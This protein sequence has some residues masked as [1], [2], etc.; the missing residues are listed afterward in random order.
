MV[1]WVDLAAADGP[2][3]V[4][5]LAR[6]PKLKGIRPMIQDIPDPD[7]MLRADLAP[8][9]RA[10]ADLDLAFDALVTPRHLDALA[11][12]L[13]RYGD[14]RV[15]IDHA[16]KPRIRD[17]QFEPW[18]DQMRRIARSSS[19][20]CKLSGLLTEAGPNCSIE[21]LR[22]Y[23]DHLLEVFGPERLVFGSDWPVLTL[24]CDYQG[25]M[26]TSRRLLD[27]L[28]PSERGRIYGSNA[29]RLY[30]LR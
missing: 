1:G 25:W 26:A 20:C 2:D 6:H 12:F 9:L 22:P 28:E 29:E 3:Q 4:A 13:E 23:V 10:V 19:A 18:A 11:T 15:I 14:L 5:A 24:A 30:R 16:A 21:R 17:G 8:A 7:W 27:H